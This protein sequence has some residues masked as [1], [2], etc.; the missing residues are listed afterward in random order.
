M[1]LHNAAFPNRDFVTLEG[2]QGRVG[3]QFLLQALRKGK[4]IGNAIG[5]IKAGDVAEEINH[6]GGAF[7]ASC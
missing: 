3:Q 2:Y 7:R 6:P 5:I 4:L 1:L